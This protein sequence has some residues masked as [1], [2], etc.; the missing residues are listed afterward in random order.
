MAA[1]LWQPPLGSLLLA[2]SSWQPP[3]GSF[4]RFARSSFLFLSEVSLGIDFGRVGLWM[5]GLALARW[6]GAL[7]DGGVGHS[8][9]ASR[10][11]LGLR[12]R[13]GKASRRKGLKS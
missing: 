13:S 8:G 5:G 11:I 3:P 10:R 4:L 2:T 12:P 1:S 9:K 6:G 7:G